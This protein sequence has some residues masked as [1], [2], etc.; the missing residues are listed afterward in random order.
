MPS[1]KTV[2][3][4]QFQRFRRRQKGPEHHAPALWALIIRNSEGECRLKEDAPGC[5]TG[6]RGKVSSGKTGRHAKAAA[7]TSFRRGAP[8]EGNPGWRHGARRRAQINIVEEVQSLG[9]EGQRVFVAS[10]GHAAASA[11]ASK[12]AATTPAAATAATATTTPAKA[13]TEATRTAAAGTA[14]LTRSACA[15]WRRNLGP[16]AK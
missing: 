2:G 7:G 6:R 14:A 10:V 12:H 11:T 5:R 13:A 15:V 9:A 3:A 1:V 4:Q 8:R 16:N